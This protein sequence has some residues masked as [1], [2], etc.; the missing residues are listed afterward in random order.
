M[1]TSAAGDGDAGGSAA[2][3]TGGGSGGSSEDGVELLAPAAGGAVRLEASGEYV[4]L[5]DAASEFSLVAQLQQHAGPGTEEGD[6]D[7][8]S[9]EE[10]GRI[11]SN[12]SLRVMAFVALCLTILLLSLA[13]NAYLLYE[14]IV[15][16]GARCDT[17]LAPWSATQ[18]VLGLMSTALLIAVS[19]PPTAEATEAERKGDSLGR[20]LRLH[21]AAPRFAR[22]P[23]GGARFAINMLGCVQ[24]LSLVWLCLGTAWVAQSRGTQGEPAACPSEL[25]WFC[26]VYLV[27]LWTLGV[28]ACAASCCG[29]AVRQLL[30][31]RRRKGAGRPSAPHG[32]PS[33]DA[34]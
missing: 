32:R 22:E 30:T 20:R 14:G 11:R 3:T 25:Y 26:F 4:T 5:S 16:A 6:H 7:G 18:G 9:E 17:P 29:M 8:Q 31:R 23:G 19:V 21:I 13:L 12:R 28:V 15:N 2:A 27:T 24:C 34:A 10:A 1:L 33:V